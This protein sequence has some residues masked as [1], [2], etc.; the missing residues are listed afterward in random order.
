VERLKGFGAK[1]QESLREKLEFHQRSLGQYH[2]RTLDLMAE[3]LVAQ[4]EKQFP[5]EAFARTGALR[6]CCP[7][8]PGIALITT[9]A[10]AAAPT[11]AEIENLETTDK[12]S[13]A[14]LD[15]FPLTLHHCTHGNFGSKQFR[16][17]GTPEFLK[18][19]VAAFPDTDFQDL[20]TEAE[21][22]ARA[23]VDPIPPELREND[24]YIGLARSG[25]LPQL[26]EAADIKGV[27]HAHSTYSDG[28]HTLRQMAE[29][30]PYLMI[31]DH[32]KTA[33]YA[34]GLSVERVKEQWAE[35]DALNQELAPFRIY[36]SI[37]R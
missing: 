29:A 8:L 5:G 13:T 19:F 23:G 25:K 21:V 28:I 18:A 7:T 24:A 16:H 10:P 32:S 33:V 35:I 36:K 34:D 12:L 14:T 4:L 37:E 26:I 9:L 15:G 1:T 17:T 2:Y 11:I 31:S 22:F 20:A 30:A 27:V 3:A 6:R